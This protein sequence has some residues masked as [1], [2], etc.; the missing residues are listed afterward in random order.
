MVK[1]IKLL[2]ISTIPFLYGCSSSTVTLGEV[3]T[4]EV[5][6][7][8]LPEQ[9]KSRI[10]NIIQPTIWGNDVVTPVETG[11]IW[12]SVFIGSELSESSFNITSAVVDVE[13]GYSATYIYKIK[14]EVH[15]KGSVYPVEAQGSRSAAWA[16]ESALRQ[17]IS[18][19]VTNI[20]K[21]AKFISEN[22]LRD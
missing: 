1:T 21:Q 12:A 3:Q 14:G 5:V 10:D 9:E 7:I 15:C 11:P 8:D 16:L 19:G 20:A 17:S 2:L 6:D 22:C 18:K 13:L 4:T